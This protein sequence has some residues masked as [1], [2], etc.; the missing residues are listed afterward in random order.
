MGR[1]R[2][3]WE[4]QELDPE[5]TKVVVDP[6]RYNVGF[7]FN[8]PFHGTHRLTV[9]LDAPYDGFEFIDGPGILVHLVDNGSF[10][11]ITLESPAGLDTIEFP[12]CGDLRIIHGRVMVVP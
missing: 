7:S 1:Q 5:W 3:R 10:D 2:R 4:L 12:M 8:C 6:F 11:T 9:R